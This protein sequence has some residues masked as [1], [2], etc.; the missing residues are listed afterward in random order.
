MKSTSLK[1]AAVSAGL[2]LLA[3]CTAGGSNGSGGEGG[4]TDILKI[5]QI[6]DVSS[7]DPAQAHVGHA[8]MPYQVVYDSLLRREPDGTLVPMLA[9]DW[10]YDDSR[11]VLTVDL[12]DDVTFSDGTPFNAEA[13]KANLDHFKGAN[14]RQAVQLTQYQ[15]TTVVDDDTV[16]IALV[17]PD[18]AMEYYLSQAAGLMA[19]PAAIAGG[20]L[21]TTPVGSGPYVFDTANS[22]R[23]SQAVFTA[24]EGY[25]DPSLQKFSGVELRNLE[26]LSARVNAILSGQVDFTTLD[27]KSA[28]QV[29]GAKL[30]VIPDYQV[31]WTG[32]SILDRAG[33][34]VPALGDVRVRQAMNYAV[35][36]ETL[37]QELQLGYGTA[38]S[39]VFGPDSSAYVSDLENRYPYDPAKAKQLLAEAGYADGFDLTLPV[40]S[41]FSTQVTAIAQ[42]LGDVGIR[43]TQETVPGP[44]YVANIVQG[45]YPAFNFNLAQTETWVAINQLVS[46][47]ATFNPFDTTSPELEALLAKVQSG[48]A[49][50]DAAAQDVNRYVTDNAWFLPLYRI[51][52]IAAYDPTALSVQAQV[53]MAIPSIYNFAPAK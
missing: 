29:E 45:R 23:D 15:S 42:Q 30:A 9:T 19:S 39:Q 26:E 51:D 50:A 37:L 34:L 43:V 35:D 52:Q 6:G 7:W 38:T 18:P 46:P 40:I 10:S 3:G 47:T 21:E 41:A 20:S 44:D 27:A 28:A 16:Q 32:T 13:V 33:Q 36:R 22:V 49:D 12:R 48:G 8:L 5:G 53:Q 17:Q 2:L 1:V 14:G 24:R 25:W 31:D 11:T 4:S